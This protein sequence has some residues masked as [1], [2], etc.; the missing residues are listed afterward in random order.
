M[1]AYVSLNAPSKSAGLAKITNVTFNMTSS[2]SIDNCFSSAYTHY[3]IRFSN[4]TATTT[5]RTR[6]RLRAAGVD[7]TTGYRRQYGQASA[8]TL[9]AARFTADTTMF[10]GYGVVHNDSQVLG[11]FTDFWL[12]HPFNS[13]RTSGRVVLNRFFSGSLEIFIEGASHDTASSYDGFTL[14]TNTGR[15]SGQVIVYGLVRS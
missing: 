1:T 11:P 3:I 6:L 7:A 10:D 4:T 15:I 5:D 2:V 9:S 13:V 8:A 14:L 12:S